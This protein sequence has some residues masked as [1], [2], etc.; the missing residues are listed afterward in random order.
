MGLWD[1]SLK[2]QRLVHG[3]Q[4]LQGM[5]HHL[6]THGHM[7]W[8]PERGGYEKQNLCAINLMVVNH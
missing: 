7:K 3:L 8:I 5:L 2:G 1:K 4:G 6:G